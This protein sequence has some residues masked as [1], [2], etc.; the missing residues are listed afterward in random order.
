MPGLG[1]QEYAKENA[2]ETADALNQINPDFIRLRT[3][4]IPDETE[5]F[6]DY[7]NGTFTRTND[8]MMVEELLHFIQA[9]NGISSTIKSDHV[10]NL[11]EEV[12][13]TFPDDKPRMMEA[14][15]W[16]LGLSRK[17]Q[18][19]FN[20]GRRTGIIHRIVEFAEPHKRALIEVLM[21]QHNINE[22]NADEMVDELMKRFI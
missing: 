11:I 13:G 20:V 2:I 9:L 16:Y 8:A 12:N 3:L 1:G 7:K 22:T 18:I 19:L 17:E 15:Q 4:A 14:L 5:L 10:L 6:K 21:D